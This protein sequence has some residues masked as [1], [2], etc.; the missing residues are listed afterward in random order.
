MHENEFHRLLPACLARGSPSGCAPQ[1]DLGVLAA[2]DL[3]EEAL[4]AAPG[5]AGEWILR[6]WRRASLVDLQRAERLVLAV[7]WL[8]PREVQGWGHLL[9]HEAGAHVAHAV[10]AAGLRALIRWRDPTA[11]AIVRGGCFEADPSLSTALHEARDELD[12]ASVPGRHERSPI[13]RARRREWDRR[14]ARRRG[15]PSP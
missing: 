10:K 2:R 3:L 8:E 9:A 4:A 7:G 13:A 15:A 12:P 6:A 5:R 1:L 14:Q 11:T